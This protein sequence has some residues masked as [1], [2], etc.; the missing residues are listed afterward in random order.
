MSQNERKLR[1]LFTRKSRWCARVW[2]S[3]FTQSEGMKI[4][5]KYAKLCK[6][7]HEI[8]QINLHRWDFNNKINATSLENSLRW[9]LSHKQK[10]LWRHFEH[11]IRSWNESTDVKNLL[12]IVYRNHLHLLCFFE[13]IKYFFYKKTFIKSF[14]VLEVLLFF[15]FS[16]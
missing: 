16:K 7:P 10:H 4:R 1:D 13:R 8:C 5:E 15:R 2:K 12:N 14:L 6:Y 9:R 3:G 11:R